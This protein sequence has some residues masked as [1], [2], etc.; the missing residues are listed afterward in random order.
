MIIKVIKRNL[1][2]M[3]QKVNM[4]SALFGKEIVEL[5][6]EENE[7]WID[8]ERIEMMVPP[9]GK[10]PDGGYFS[11]KYAGNIIF[12][13]DNCYE[14][15]LGAWEKSKNRMKKPT[16]NTT[17]CSGNTKKSLNWKKK[18]RS[19]ANAK[20]TIKALPI[21]NSRPQSAWATTAPSPSAYAP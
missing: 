21:R 20:A 18:T 15:L 7:I 13:K 14:E 1:L 12:I 4:L 8:T 17:S 11:I 10:E 5:M 16:K 6:P 3:K 19:P 2:G 9:V